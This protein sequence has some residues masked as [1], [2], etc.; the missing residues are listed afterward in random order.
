M[1]NIPLIGSVNEKKK[2]EAK[3][4]ESESDSENGCLPLFD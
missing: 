3:K 2:E 1:L 4:E